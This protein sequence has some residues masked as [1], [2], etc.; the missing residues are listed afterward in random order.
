MYNYN[1]AVGDR[2]GLRLVDIPKAQELSL[3]SPSTPKRENK[4][5]FEILK[6]LGSGTYG[7][8]MMAMDHKTNEEVGKNAWL[9]IFFS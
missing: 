4:Q 9:L 5:R 8:V 3:D 2:T 6:K 1:M 7:K